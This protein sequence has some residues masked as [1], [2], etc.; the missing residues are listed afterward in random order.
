MKSLILFTLVIFINITLYAQC[1]WSV[2]FYDD[3]E[4]NNVDPGYVQGT[5]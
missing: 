4:H 1:D 3:F 5:A 2:V